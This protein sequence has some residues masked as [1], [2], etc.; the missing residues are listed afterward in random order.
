MLVPFHKRLL[1]VIKFNI[2]FFVFIVLFYIVHMIRAMLF[3]VPAYN[4]EKEGKNG[5]QRRDNTT[6]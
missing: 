3:T 5:E 1:Y 4:K 2:K 6:D